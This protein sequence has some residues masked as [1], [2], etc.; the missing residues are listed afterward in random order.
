LEFD[1][2]AARR[3]E[4]LYQI[5]DAAHRR[6]LVR[7]A[8][9]AVRGDRILDVG[10]GPGFY[11]LELAEIVGS[12]GS[13]VGVDSSHPMLELARARCAGLDNIEL[14]EGEATALPVESGTFDGAVCVQVLE[15]VSDVD[16]AVAELHRAL[17]PG[18]R[19]VVWDVDW[20]TVS[21][22]SRDNALTTRVLRAWDEHLADPS[23]PRTLGAHLRSGGFEDVRAE[24]HAFATNGRDPESYG[25]S[26]VPF[27]ATFVAGRQGIDDV[28]AEAWG[29][30]QRELMERNEFYFSSTQFC[31]TATRSS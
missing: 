16:E 12:S 14:I 31:F 29:A 8:L 13:V 3:I 2:E 17:R 1:A 20:A 27:I 25:A 5:R 4:A 11:C 9:G 21:I 24:A 7:E 18:G 15:Y 30:E 6:E 28:E 26:L 10:C 23:L 22:H 19:A